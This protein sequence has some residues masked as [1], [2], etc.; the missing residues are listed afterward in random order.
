M[1]D[2][3]LRKQNKFLILLTVTIFLITL[4][5][6][7]FLVTIDQILL[8]IFQFSL[9]L[10]IITGI[11]KTIRENILYIEKWK[12]INQMELDAFP[13]ENEESVRVLRG[14]IGNLNFKFTKD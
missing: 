6:S 8:S 3:Y 9:F 7:I 13:I 12:Q 1:V 14:N 10:V 2:E 4:S 11:I 5:L